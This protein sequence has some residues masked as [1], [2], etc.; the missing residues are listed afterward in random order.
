MLKRFTPL[1]EGDGYFHS[2]GHDTAA[3]APSVERPAQPKVPDLHAD[4]LHAR[5]L[6]AAAVGGFFSRL[7][8]WVE[9]KIQMAQWREI[10]AYLSRSTDQVDLERRLNQ[11]MRD[12][13]THFG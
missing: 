2:E 11:I 1:Y 7:M 10:D 6:R 8:D 3:Q 4:E 5:A 13:R 12:G 9:R